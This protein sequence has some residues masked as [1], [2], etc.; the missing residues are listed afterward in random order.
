MDTS[1]RDLPGQ[2]YFGAEPNALAMNADGT[3]LYV[4]N[5]GSDAVAVIDPRKLKSL[6]K[7][8]G[9]VEPLGFAPTELMPIALASSSGK[10]YIVTDKGKG[11]GPNNF[12]QRPLQGDKHGKH[13]S[14]TFT[15]SPTLLYGSIA[16][17]DEDGLDGMSLKDSTN[18][19]DGVE[20]DDGGAGRTP[21][22]RW[23]ESDQACDLHH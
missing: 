6:A 1:I 2:S 17:V 7:A 11:T 20:P 3:R 19:C 12:A 16:M 9:M 23:E 14:S 10:L 18:V 13:G 4:A 22:C 21:I 5:M 15:Y 8:K